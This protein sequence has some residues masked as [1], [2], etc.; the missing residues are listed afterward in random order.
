MAAEVGEQLLAPED[1]WQRIDNDDEDINYK[2]EWIHSGASEVGYYNTPL[3]YTSKEGS[4]ILFK[5]K[6]SQLRLICAFYQ[7]RSS[8]IEISIDGFVETFSQYGDYDFSNWITQGICY[9]KTGLSD[10]IHMVK[11][12]LLDSNYLDLDAIDIDEDGY[13]LPYSKVTNLKAIGGDEEVTLSWDSVEDAE[14]YKVYWGEKSGDYINSTTVSRDSYEGYTIE[15]LDDDTRYYFA[16][17]ALIA[18]V[19]KELSYE[20][21]ARTDEEVVI[22]T[23]SALLIIT[24]TNG[25]VN[26]Y[27]VSLSEVD[28]FVVWLEESYEND[29]VPYYKFEKAYNIGPFSSR[30]DYILS[31][32]ILQFEVMEY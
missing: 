27:E 7:N 32:K 22:T 20:T 28:K 24:M 17:S 18:G 5:F 14:E 31:D 8:N 26:E 13:L 23:S 9:E 11:I 10:E 25:K 15:N 29:N 21:S 12:T 3:Y 19:E 4:Q 6:G 16:V 2:G 30:V 1:G